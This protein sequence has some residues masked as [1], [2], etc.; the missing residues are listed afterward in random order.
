MMMMMLKAG[1]GH[2]GFGPPFFPTFFD[3]SRRRRLVKGTTKPN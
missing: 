1:K 2:D 3:V